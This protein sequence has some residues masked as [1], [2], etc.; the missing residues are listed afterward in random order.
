MT[1]ENT[2][3]GQ[4]Y[5]WAYDDAGGAI[6]T[7]LVRQSLPVS[8]A[9]TVTLSPGAGQDFSLGSVVSDTGGNVNSVVKTGAGT[10]TLLTANTHTGATTIDG[11]ALSISSDGNLGAAPGALV[12][13]QLTLNGGGLTSTATFSTATT[14]GVT[15]G[16][17]GGT[18]EVAGGTTL[19]VPAPI[20]GAGGLIKSGTGTLRLSGTSTFGGDTDVNAGTLLVTGSVSGTVKANNTGTVGGTGSVG[21][22]HANASAT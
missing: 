19:S 1:F 2:Q 5:D 20:V 13:G 17:A 11:G 6:V 9:Q 16:A 10:T 14:R 21:T 7:G 22:L 8:S 12:A 15:L 18:I 4:I 3:P